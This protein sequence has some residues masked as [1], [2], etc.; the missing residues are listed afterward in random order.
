MAHASVFVLPVYAITASVGSHSSLT[1]DNLARKKSVSGA[2]A[3]EVFRRTAGAS[4]GR[5]KQ[6][7]NGFDP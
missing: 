7:K 3:M 6:L 5:R 4:V 1:I 2:R